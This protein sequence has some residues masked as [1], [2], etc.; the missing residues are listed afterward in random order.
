MLHHTRHAEE[1]NSNPAETE[2]VAFSFM[3]EYICLVGHKGT[4]MT[5]GQPVVHQDTHVLVLQDPKKT[6]P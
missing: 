4:L 1:N 3:T 5:C 2:T 6:G